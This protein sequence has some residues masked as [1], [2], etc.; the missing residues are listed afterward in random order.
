MIEIHKSIIN[1]KSL[2]EIK[3]KIKGYDR[4]LM[5]SLNIINDKGKLI[6]FMIDN[7]EN[8]NIVNDFNITN[9]DVELK[10][11]GC[12]YPNRINEILLNDFETDYIYNNLLNSLDKY[13]LRLFK[14]NRNNNNFKEIIINYILNNH[15]S[16]NLIK[17]EELYNFLLKIKKLSFRN[18]YDC[19]EIDVKNNLTDINLIDKRA[20]EIN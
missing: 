14:I 5:R 15:N 16:K 6:N 2:E 1:D 9:E 18:K 11:F 12:I 4:S 8:Y 7:P 20:D 19:Y 10:L 3:K 17:P 13:N